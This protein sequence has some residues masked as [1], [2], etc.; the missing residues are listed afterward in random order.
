[1]GGCVGRGG[2]GGEEGGGWLGVGWDHVTGVV[3]IPDTT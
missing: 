3:V 1:M 2:V